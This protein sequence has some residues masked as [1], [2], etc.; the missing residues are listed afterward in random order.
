MDVLDLAREGLHLGGR[1][2]VHLVGRDACA[3]LAQGLFEGALTLLGRCSQVG[4]GQPLAVSRKQ[5][6]GEPISCC[7]PRPSSRPSGPRGIR[8]RSPAD[9]LRRRGHQG[10]RDLPAAQAVM[11][12]A[13]E[14]A[15]MERSPSARLRVG[16][17]GRGRRFR[18]AGW[19][20]SR[21]WRSRRARRGDHALRGGAPAAIVCGELLI[22]EELVE[23]G[24]HAE[25]RPHLEA[26]PQGTPIRK[27][28]GA[29]RTPSMVCMVS[30]GDS[31]GRPSEP[32]GR[33]ACAIR[34]TKAISRAPT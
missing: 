26:S 3:A 31:E 10:H 5:G 17:R 18:P 8:R 30:C 23:H 11:K 12:V 15:R 33:S 32:T 24:L 16:A 34:A 6:A 29:R 14:P 2:Y 7:G 13:S 28:S 22:G 19:R 4:I 20:A 25:Q 27:A 9:R 21:S 1:R